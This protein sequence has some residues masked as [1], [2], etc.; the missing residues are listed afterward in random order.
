MSKK[1]NKNKVKKK[2]IGGHTNPM[3]EAIRINNILSKINIDDSV[4]E[5]INK[6]NQ[7]NN[8]ILENNSVQV[9]TQILENNSVIKK[10][11]DDSY[12]IQT[13]VE[14]DAVEVVNKP[15][16]IGYLKDYGGCGHFR[17][18]YPMNLI[19]SRFSFSGKINCTLFPNM[20]V[21]DDLVPHVRAFVFQRPITEEST[22]AINAYKKFQKEYQY[23]LIAELDDYVFEVPSYHPAYSTNTI[24]H[25]RMLLLN[26]AKM[27]E[28]IVSTENLK[29]GLIELGITNKITVIENYLPKYLYKTDV[30]RFRLNDIKKPTIAYTGSDYH[31]NNSLKLDGDFSE[32][33]KEFILKNIDNYNFIF[34]GNVPEFLREHANDGKIVIVPF[35]NPV[36]YSTNLKNY[37]ADFFIAPLA[38]NMFNACKSDLRYLESSAMGSV[39]IGSKF[40]GEFTSP[41]QKCPI[42]IT[43]DS[44]VEDIEKIIN[45]NLNKDNFNNILSEQYDSL[46]NRWLENN[47]NIFKYVEAYSSGVAGV[48]VDE[49]HPQYGQ[50][51]DFLN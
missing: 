47:Q 13:Y 24:E 28:I 19:N 44:T 51:K 42:T 33:I 39:F 35:T 29:N 31:Y 16:V 22:Y 49:D 4:T 50:V 43:A 20:L 7:L 26:L 8:K 37:R 40:T 18:I 17:M 3:K 9:A 30:K 46:D 2:Y 21:Q 5:S 32:N 45:S 38:E 11:T 23:K 36:E 41:Y 12:R 34:F 6:V 25:T 1:K 27:D 10:M 48:K 14:K 15:Y